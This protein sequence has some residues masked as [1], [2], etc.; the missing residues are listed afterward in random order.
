MRTSKMGE[1]PDC[2]RWQ[3]VPGDGQQA[4]VAAMGRARAGGAARPG[5]RPGQREAPGQG[6]ESR[7]PVPPAQPA[8][9][10][11]KANLRS[12]GTQAGLR[13]RHHPN[14]ESRPSPLSFKGARQEG[15]SY[16]VGGAQG[17]DLRPSEATS[18]HDPPGREQPVSLPILFRGMD[19]QRASGVWGGPPT[20]RQV[21]K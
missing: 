8:V 1:G 19:S 18:R 12:Q 6:A 7:A 15:C 5:A 3:H 17:L 14:P 21:P 20:L 4:E 10:A 9:A 11:E 2:E 13:E 16:G